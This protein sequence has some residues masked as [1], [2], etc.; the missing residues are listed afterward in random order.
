MATVSQD[1]SRMTFSIFTLNP[2]LKPTSD[3]QTQKG[4]S[5]SSIIR[6]K[7]YFQVLLFRQKQNSSINFPSIKALAGFLE[8]SIQDI[9]ATLN[10]LQHMG[11][12]YKIAHAQKT[13]LVWDSLQEAP[14]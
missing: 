3:S 2:F 11:F 8:V 4:I 10:E 14:I 12:D 1:L 13:L 6:I 5:D 7:E 9:L